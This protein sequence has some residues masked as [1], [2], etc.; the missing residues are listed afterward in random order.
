MIFLCLILLACVPGPCL[1]RPVPSMGHLP[2]ISNETIFGSEDYRKEVYHEGSFS[3]DPKNKENLTNSF[4]D[5]ILKILD[6]EVPVNMTTEVELHENCRKQE[7][8]GYEWDLEPKTMYAITSAVVAFVLFLTGAVV[9]AKKNGR[10]SN[11]RDG[12]D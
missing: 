6:P 9:F 2:K 4:L 3:Y 1:N 10:S 5:P 12:I 11:Q 8:D 7:K